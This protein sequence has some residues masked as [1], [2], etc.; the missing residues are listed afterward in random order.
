MTPLSRIVTE[1]P[2]AAFS[3]R[4]GSKHT[5]PIVNSASRTWP[6][7]R[8]L[9]SNDDS[10]EILAET[11]SGSAEWPRERHIE[12]DTAVGNSVGRKDT[13]WKSTVTSAAYGDRHS[14]PEHGFPL[15]AIRVEKGLE[16]RSEDV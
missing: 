8:R 5:T 2:R 10:R 14:D 1:G 4:S 6:G 9:P 7:G 15:N 16:W 3:K 13:R 12:S 11:T